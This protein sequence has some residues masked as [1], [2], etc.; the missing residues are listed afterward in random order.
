MGTSHLPIIFDK[1]NS[2]L[3]K[4]FEKAGI[5]IDVADKITIRID[6]DEIREF[7]PQYHKTNIKTAE[8]GNAHIIQK[9]ATKGLD[10]LR[11]YCLKNDISFIHDGTF[12]NYDTMKAV[13]KKALARNRI[14]FVYYIYLDPLVAWEFTKAREALEGRNIRKD[15]FIDQFYGAQES[16]D[17]IKRKFGDKVLIHFILKN[18]KNEVEK[19][20]F[21][22]TD[23]A[24]YMEN[25]YTRQAIKKYSKED[26]SDLLR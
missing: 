25:Q 10:Y 6:V 22:Q 11:D 13:I 5:D 26:L 2:A 4:A 18:E 23:I 24:K 15:K 7:L 1:N 3:V 17:R 12:S 9:A 19:I 20:E 14:V 8:K 16:V 21:N